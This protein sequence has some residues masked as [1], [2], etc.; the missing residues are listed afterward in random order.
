[1]ALLSAHDLGLA[2]GGPPLLQGATFQI[3]KGDRIGLVGRNGTG[4]SML[5]S[6]LAGVRDADAGE[7]VRQPGLRVAFLP[8]EVPHGVV[9]QSLL[10]SQP[11]STHLSQPVAVQTESDHVRMSPGQGK[12]KTPQNV[13]FGAA[14]PAEQSDS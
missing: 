13:P 8:Q 9:P 1:M 4:K 3:D 10:A 2:A 12:P 6:V 7:V 5:L 11:A 14:G